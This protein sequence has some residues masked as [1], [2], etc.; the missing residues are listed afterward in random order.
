VLST[1]TAHFK[2]ISVKPACVAPCCG[3]RRDKGRRLVKIVGNLRERITEARINGWLGEV[4]GLQ[5]SL[6]AAHN[7]LTTWIA[8]SN[9]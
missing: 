1:T 2:I 9:G 6:D 4:Q 8:T 5:V 7:K 3:F